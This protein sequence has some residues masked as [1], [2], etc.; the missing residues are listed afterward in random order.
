[1]LQA[2]TEETL[3]FNYS[4]DTVQ[5]AIENMEAYDASFKAPV[6]LFPF[7]EFLHRQ[8]TI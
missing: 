3:Q 8:P 4:V 6:D 2:N 5:R 1:M 7:P